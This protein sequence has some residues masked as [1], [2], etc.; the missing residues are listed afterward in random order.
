[1]NLPSSYSYTMLISWKS[2]SWSRITTTQFS[3]EITTDVL[4]WVDDHHGKSHGRPKRCA[5]ARARSPLHCL[6]GQRPGRGRPLRGTARRAQ[7]SSQLGLR[8]G[9]F[10]GN[11]LMVISRF[12]GWFCG[13]LDGVYCGLMVIQWDFMVMH[14]NLNI[15]SVM[16][17]GTSESSINGGL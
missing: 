16:K 10:R 12:C 8:P 6:H 1:M 15:T 9:E 2:S 14:G 5:V 17:H 4:G 7:L 11:G 3:R 13:W